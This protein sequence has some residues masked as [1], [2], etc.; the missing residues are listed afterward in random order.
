MALEKQSLYQ[1]IFHS[2]YREITP[3]SL[4]LGFIIGCFMAASFT[5]AGMVLGFTMSAAAVASIIGWGVLKKIV[6]KGT[7]VENNINQTIA[8]AI[9]NGCSGVIFTVPVLFIRHADFNPWMVAAACTAGAILGVAFII[10]V[11]KQ[12]I[13]LER[14]RFPTGTAVATILK[15]PGAGV[16]KA[17]LLVWGTLA[18]AVIYFITQLPLLKLPSILPET[19]NLGRLIGLPEYVD[20]TMAISLFSF[21]AGFITGKM[22]LTVLA[23]GALAYW[24]IT[25]VAVQA[26]WIPKVIDL[27]FMD[28]FAHDHMNRP[29]GIGMLIGG[30]LTG[31]VLAFPSIKSAI[32]SLRSMEMKGGNLEEMPLKVLAFAIVGAFAVLFLATYYTASIGIF[33]SLVVALLGVI[34]MMFAGIIIAECTGLTDWS[35]ISGMALVAVIVMLFVTNNHVITA[36]LIGATVCVAITQCADMMQDLKT[37]YLIGGVPIRQQL[38]EITFA[39]VGAIISIGTLYLLWKAYGFGGP[40]DRISAPQAQ[41]LNAAIN[42]ILG[43]DVPYDKYL[44]GGLIGILLSGSGISGLGV[45]IGISMYLPLLYIIPYGFGCLANQFVSIIKGEQWTEEW[46]VP[47]AAGFIAGETMLVLVFALLTVAGF[48]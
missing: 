26:G 47:V 15:S 25:P 16:Q 13:D 10:P 6:K 48:I 30:A 29:L 1:T 35:P 20:A 39:W 46:G 12:M 19:I 38:I 17:K 23:G 36:V 11:R 14:L 28:S 34:W 41:A 7:I 2:K 43:G 40:G 44:T 27:S 33:M 8:S 37:G 4:I 31:I 45:L 22:G 32:Q 24:I 9:N 5:Y 21:G 3:E 18:S 42:G